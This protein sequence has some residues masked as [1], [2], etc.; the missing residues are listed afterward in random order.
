MVMEIV[1]FVF[2]LSTAAVVF[3]YA[4]Y[5][6]ALRLI[7][8]IA[9]R[10]ISPPPPGWMLPTV[11]MLIPLHNERAIIE[12]KLAN[13]RALQY[14]AERLEVVFI[15]DGC[16]D[17]TTEYLRANP[18]PRVRVLERSGRGGKGAALNAALEQTHHE[19]VVFSDA[20]IMLQPDALQQIVGPLASAEVGCVSG[21][22]RIAEAGGEGLY[23]RYELSLRR[24]ESQLHSIVGASGSFYAQRR[25]LCAPFIY[26]LAP[27][28]LSVLH[29][30]EQGF[31]AVAEPSAW[32][33]MTELE[34]PR[35]EFN[36]KV[37]T[38]LRGITT[39]VRYAHLFNPF[40]YGWFAFEL[41]AHKV[42]RWLV[43]FFLI[44]LVV[45]SAV[46]AA[47]GSAFYTMAFAAQAIFY[48]LALVALEGPT[49]IAGWLPARIS[50]YFTAANV[51]TASAWLR[52]FAG[53]RQELWSPSRR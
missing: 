17:G 49:R 10:P 20:S 6:I 4:G 3:T 12:R 51:A 32:G 15:C 33:R 7:V 27:D 31:R 22:D 37:R 45:S 13:V 14:P 9:P 16:S 44:A 48:V 36:R 1:A 30:V 42:M 21:E 2:W 43:P 28:F 40:R 29:T 53:T 11:T 38:I 5:A 52:F 47:G 39:L 46:L 41:F 23:G 24:L 34:D 19:I 35:A 8:R 26:G 50:L 25:V 18:S